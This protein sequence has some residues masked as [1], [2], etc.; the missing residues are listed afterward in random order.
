M[1]KQLILQAVLIAVNS[2]F[3]ASE[4]AFVSLNENKIKKLAKE[5][6]KKAE[7]VLSLIKSPTGML[8]AI[9]ICI[10]LAGFL[11]SAFAA[12]GFSEILV[13]FL[14]DDLGIRFVPEKVLDSISVVLITIILS[15]FTLVL[16]E[17][18]PKRVAMKKA[19]KIALSVA[20]ILGFLCVVLKPVVWF[21]SASTNIVM[22]IL[23]IDPQEAEE[24]ASEEDI[25]MLLGEGSEQGTI[26][27][28]AK[29]M[30]E[31][32][33]ELDNTP[34]SS[35]MVHRRDMTV[36]KYS[37]SCEDILSVIRESGYSRIPV[38]GENSDDILGIIR[39]KEY[40][41][42]MW[43]DEDF[44]LS[45]IIH[46]PK[47]VPSNLKAN[48]LLKQMQATKDHMAIIIDEYGG[49]LGLVTLEDLLEEIVGNIYDE[50]DEDDLPE[51][52]KVGEMTYIIS[53]DANVDEVVRSIGLPES[54]IS[55]DYSTFAGYV[56]SRICAIPDVL[57][58]VEFYDDGMF[59]KVESAEER[60]I[61]SVRVSLKENVEK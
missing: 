26:D 10:T 30:I 17:L 57:T 25:L 27:V 39:T 29:E 24:A 9:Q 22:K 15:Y 53:A 18:V 38:V 20:G 7:K 23:G 16:G 43:S 54:I 21:L 41:I 12:D 48:V 19:E 31:N 55:E 3:A 51:I 46:A 56:F 13:R 2:V 52:T 34:V 4:M 1:F 11:G 35:M 58:D 49:V 5:G 59:V 60:K 6:D 37:D 45:S 33:F 28:E 36:I 61:L 40:L 14:V 50:T 44:E 8:S 47:F 32:V 42:R